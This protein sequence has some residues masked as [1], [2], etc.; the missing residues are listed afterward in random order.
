M[1]QKL[2][3]AVP[4]AALLAL[5]VQPLQAQLDPANVMA[6]WPLNETESSVLVAEDV[7][8]GDN[9]AQIKNDFTAV[10]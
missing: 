10:P 1:K 4:V 9:S 7:S 8:A 6:Y 2:L 3:L 5:T